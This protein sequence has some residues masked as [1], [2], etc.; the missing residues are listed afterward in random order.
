MTSLINEWTIAEITDTPTAPEPERST[1]SEVLDSIRDIVHRRTGV[2]LTGEVGVRLDPDTEEVII[3]LCGVTLSDG[4]DIIAPPKKQYSYA[5]TVTIEVQVHG[6]VEAASD[7]E[8]EELAECILA[9]VEADS[10]PEVSSYEDDGLEVDEYSTS[11]YGEVHS[12]HCEE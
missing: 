9:S 6:Y 11:A 2:D 12:V 10:T 1:R 4:G 7:E 8:A 5:G 3:S